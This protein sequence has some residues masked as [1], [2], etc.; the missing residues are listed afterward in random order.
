MAAV[1]K[2][3]LTIK[4]TQTGCHGVFLC[5]KSLAQ[6]NTALPAGYL[7]VIR[8][9]HMKFIFN[10]LTIFLIMLL[11]SCTSEQDSEVS[12]SYVSSNE[13]IASLEPRKT[14]FILSW[15]TTQKTTT[16]KTLIKK[17]GKSEA[18]NKVGK[19]I[20]KN[21]DKYLVE[22]TANMENSYFEYFSK[23]ELSLLHHDEKFKTLAE[24][25]KKVTQ[26]GLSMKSKSTKLI[27][28]LTTESLTSVYKSI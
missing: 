17:L 19:E 22:W 14:L 21:L 23:Q 16:W 20:H 4:L 3:K 10:T 27:E 11:I 5:S 1:N 24:T 28:L 12:N 8:R 18:K 7:S 13:Y 6:K 26:V 25:K 9:R 2:Q 15:K